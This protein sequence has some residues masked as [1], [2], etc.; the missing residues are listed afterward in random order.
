MA[1]ST[2]KRA[3]ITVLLLA[4]LGGAL[5][6][7]LRG[8]QTERLTQQQAIDVASAPVLNGLIALDVEGY[9]KDERVQRALAAQKL[10]VQV[11]RMGS[12]DMAS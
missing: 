3:A 2:G 11:L 10:P 1:L 9:F 4:V 6:F 12:R 8:Q 7:A 5:F